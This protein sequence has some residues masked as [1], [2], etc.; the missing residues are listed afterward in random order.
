MMVYLIS[1]ASFFS[2]VTTQMVFLNPIASHFSP[3][4]T[5]S[6]MPKFLLTLLFISVLASQGLLVET[7]QTSSED[8][9]YLGRFAEASSA[10]QDL[11]WHIGSDP[12]DNHWSGVYCD[13][14]GK[15]KLINLQGRGLL[16]TVPDAENGSL[17]SLQ[18]LHL[19][20]NTFTGALPLLA[21][22]QL[23]SLRVDSNGFTSMPEKFFIGMPS[24]EEFN[25]TN[26]T[27]LH[28]WSLSDDIRSLHLLFSFQA[29]YAGINGTLQGLF[30]NNSAGFPFPS[31][32]IVSMA[33]NRL[34]GTMPELKGSMIGRLDLSNNML[35]GSMDFITDLAASVENLQLSHNTFTGPLPDF[36]K[37][38]SL[39]MLYIDHNR[40][41]GVVPPS[42]PQIETL[43]W[44]HLS[45]NLLQGPLPEF[46]SYVHTDVAK[47][48][49]TGSFC[50]L[51]R[52]PCAPE[53]KSLLL[54]AGAFGYP[55]NLATSW[56]RNDACAGWIGVHCDDRRR[57][58]GINLSRLNLNGTI[59]SAF[60]SLQAL[61]A[62][63]L[64]GNNIDGELPT[65]VAQLPLLHVLDV[66][67]NNLVGTMPKFRNDVA[68]WIEGNPLLKVSGSPLSAL[69]TVAV[70]ITMMVT[71]LS[72]L[73]V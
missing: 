50:R 45:G 7:V 22:P 21:L 23:S 18:E 61:E 6:T 11:G 52:G 53:V 9:A 14:A 8:L 25:I 48:A 24:L 29:S 38:T 62:V 31:L 49:A 59:D 39:A 30:R 56:M 63:I 13:N 43:S 60:G 10:D 5:T 3:Q 68:V 47:A 64:S 67:N 34:T 17:S 66:S 1:M 71:V 58:T 28:E 20:G 2:S 55:H 16:G 72:F 57:V 40:I 69:S 51:D 26:N 35:S 32:A 36:S 70:L 41:S 27:M 46:N 33:A 65:S 37:F 54:I 44:V 15:V 73:T 12:C 19:G 42:L 4:T